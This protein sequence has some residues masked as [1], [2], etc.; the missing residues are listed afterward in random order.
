MSS[1]KSSS[2]P[3]GYEMTEKEVCESLIPSF[4]KLEDVLK[5]A[6]QVITNDEGLKELI[7]SLNSDYK[8][9]LDAKPDDPQCGVIEMK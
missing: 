6:K 8:N 1:K 9:L 4:V 2:L 7:L 3:I 5:D